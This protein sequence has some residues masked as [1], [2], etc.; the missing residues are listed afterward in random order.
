MEKPTERSFGG[1]AVH[2]KWIRGFAS[3]DY[4]GFAFFGEFTHIL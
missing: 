4:S 2:G 1:P 3:P